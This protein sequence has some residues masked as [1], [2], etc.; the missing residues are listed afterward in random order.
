MKRFEAKSFRRLIGVGALLAGGSMALGA[1]GSE[2]YCTAT[3]LAIQRTIQPWMQR[4]GAEALKLDK[5]F[6]DSCSITPPLDNKLEVFCSKDVSSQALGNQNV[7]L[8]AEMYTL[9]GQPDPAST[10][11][12]YG[13]SVDQSGLKTT[14]NFQL[15]GPQGDAQA[16]LLNGPTYGWQAIEYNYVQG[17]GE[18]NPPGELYTA[19]AQGWVEGSNSQPI[20]PLATAKAVVNDVPSDMQ[21]VMA[22]FSQ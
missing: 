14:T 9:G 10:F 3:E 7:G 16:N 11:Y 17:S 5:E 13:G 8:E 1:G 21:A 4:L 2:G 12:I 18:S 19:S 22:A 15:I 6:P 20:G